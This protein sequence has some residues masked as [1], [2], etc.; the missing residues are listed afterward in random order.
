MLRH[1][2]ENQPWFSEGKCGKSLP[3]G[4]LGEVLLL[5]FLIPDEQDSLKPNGLVSP[6]VN[7]HSK[8]GSSNN[9]PSNDNLGQKHL[10]TSQPLQPRN[11]PF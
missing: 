8:I 3:G 9:L 4:K 11:P 7:A 6:E 1:Q 5:L 2:R 10:S